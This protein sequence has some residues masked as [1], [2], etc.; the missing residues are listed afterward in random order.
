MRLI[1]LARVP[2]A[3]LAIA[4]Y[5]HPFVRQAVWEL[6]YRGNRAV[7]RLVAA[8]VADEL[9]AIARI[10]TK[11]IA[12][13]P[14]PNSARRRRERGWN[15]TELIAQYIPHYYPQAQIYAH[16]LKKIRHT[17]AQAT[18]KS[19]ARLTN[20][21]GSFKTANDIRTKI[22]ANTLLILLDDVTTTGA[23]FAEAF[24]TLFVRGFTDIVC[25]AFAH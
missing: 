12:I 24:E 6:K 10:T 7:A 14:L 18:L 5:R 3:T 17:P 23:T 15:Q 25:I 2:C 19:R 21:A 11:K 13:I 20:L 16:M 4:N 8:L 9:S 22:D 1:A